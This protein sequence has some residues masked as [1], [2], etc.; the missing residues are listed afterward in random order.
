MCSPTAFAI[1]YLLKITICTSSDVMDIL[2]RDKFL[3]HSLVMICDN[4]KSLQY[5]RLYEQGFFLVLGKCNTVTSFSF[6][7]ILFSMFWVNLFYFI[8]VLCCV[9][10]PKTLV[11]IKT[12]YLTPLTFF[13]LFKCSNFVAKLLLLLLDGHKKIN[14][15]VVGS[16]L[17]E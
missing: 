12:K 16:D 8:R 4:C 9:E 14:F 17:L 7:V 15:I 13:I 1:H 5:H 3:L 11:L 10:N 6:T 2:V